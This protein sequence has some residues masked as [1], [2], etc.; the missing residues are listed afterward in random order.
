L[1]LAARLDEFFDDRVGAFVERLGVGVDFAAAFVEQFAAAMEGVVEAVLRDGARAA[2]APAGLRV[3]PHGADVR[4][5]RAALA[6][7]PRQADAL[8]AGAGER[9]PR[10]LA[11]AIG[12]Q[13]RVGAFRERRQVLEQF[14]AVLFGQFER[15][16]A[17]AVLLV[18]EQLGRLLPV[19]L[20]ADLPAVG[21]P[22]VDALDVFDAHRCVLRDA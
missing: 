6:L 20:D 10:L 11:R 4:V 17:P 14:V 13:V 9:F 15:F 1:L 19:A 7:R 16:L 21:A 5:A 18:A 8:D 22:R 12:V 3:G 2:L